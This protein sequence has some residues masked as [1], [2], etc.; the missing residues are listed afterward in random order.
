MKYFKTF[1]IL[2]SSG[3]LFSGC[4]GSLSVHELMD[5]HTEVNSVPTINASLGVVILEEATFNDV[6]L[7]VDG[8]GGL[9]GYINAPLSGFDVEE[10]RQA[11]KISL[12]KSNMFS[13]NAAHRINVVIRK[14]DITADKFGLTFDAEAQGAYSASSM[15]NDFFYETTVESKGKSELSEH[16]AAGPRQKLAISR[17]ITNNFLEFIR[18]FQTHVKANTQAVAKSDQDY[19]EDSAVPQGEVD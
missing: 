4:A 14:L 12:N 10:M 1:F 15:K 2:L 7:D 18:R 5:T 8:V 13:P 16:L 11:F 17:A 6:P 19:Q 3:F 9:K